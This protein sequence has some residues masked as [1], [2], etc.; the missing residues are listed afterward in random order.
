MCSFS[1]H[2]LAAGVVSTIFLANNPA[3]GRQCYGNGC[4]ARHAGGIAATVIG[5]L[6]LEVE[7]LLV[8]SV[9]QIPRVLRSELVQIA[10]FCRHFP[11]CRA[12]G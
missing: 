7:V 2:A 3:V 6:I 1:A 12:R 8:R 10:T 11:I 4:S 9:L 5:Y